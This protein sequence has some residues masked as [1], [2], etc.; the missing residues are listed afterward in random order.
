MQTA[1]A[2]KGEQ[3]F[4]KCA[5]CHTINAGG[6]NGIGPNLHGVLG[7]AI[8]TGR[9]GFAF[10]PAGKSHAGTWGGSCIKPWPAYPRPSPG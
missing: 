4:G 3:V 9:G 7:E 6:A 2:A 10:S 8:A 5:A 1:D